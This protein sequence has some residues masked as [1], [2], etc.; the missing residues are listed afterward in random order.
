MFR[1]CTLFVFG[2]SSTLFLPSPFILH[3]YKAI[4]I[5]GLTP[6]VR[7]HDLNWSW[8]LSQWVNWLNYIHSISLSLLGLICLHASHVYPGLHGVSELRYR[9]NDSTALW[10][11][12]LAHHPAV[13]F[14]YELSL[15]DG[16][17]LQSSRV[18]NTKLHLPG[19]EESKSYVLDVWEQCD[20]QWESEHSLVYFEGANSS[21]SLLMRAAGPGQ[22]QGQPV[23]SVIQLFSWGKNYF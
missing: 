3:A 19:L 9:S 10:L 11:S 4:G 22:D 5:I 2:L 7:R 14:L 13:A 15:K 16:T 23:L 18:T 12:S 6:K 8:L 17:T 21:L 1:G 20:G